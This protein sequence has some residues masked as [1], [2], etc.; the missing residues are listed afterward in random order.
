MY[1][2]S[3]I[4]YYRYQPANGWVPPPIVVV[5]GAPVPP[6]T[7]IPLTGG[8]LPEVVPPAGAAN[9]IDI[10]HFDLDPSN[11]TYQLFRS[12]IYTTV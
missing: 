6:P 7:N 3:L 2:I 8:P 5:P 4:G 1:C 12:C 9:K 11:G 10:V